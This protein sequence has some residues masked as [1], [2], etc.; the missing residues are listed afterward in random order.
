MGKVEA[1]NDE[2]TWGEFK[3]LIDAAGVQDTDKIG[4][5]EVYPPIGETGLQVQRNEKKR[6]FWV[7]DGW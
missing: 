4:S 3:R 6:R 2:I 7:Q 1:D 5:I